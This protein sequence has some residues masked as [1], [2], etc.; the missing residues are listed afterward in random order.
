[1]PIEL[2]CPQCDTLLRVPDGSE[3]RAARCPSCQAMLRVPSPAQPGEN[4]AA[5]S[6]APAQQTPE[7]TSDWSADSS[8]ET[9][10]YVA[11]DR[12]AEEEDNP[13]AAPLAEPQA[14]ILGG[15]PF[16]LT[17]ARRL[18]VGDVFGAAQALYGRN[19]L[20]CFFGILVTTFLPWIPLAAYLLGAS[21]LWRQVYVPSLP[22]M[23]AMMIPLGVLACWLYAGM[24]RMT[25]RAGREGRTQFM[26]LFRTGKEFVSWLILAVMMIVLF[27]IGGTVIGGVL[28]GLVAAA[29]G[30]NNAGFILGMAIPFAIWLTVGPVFAVFFSQ[31][32][33]LIVDR[34][35]GAWSALGES[36]KL[37]AGYRWKLLLIFA[38]SIVGTFGASVVPFVSLILQPLW[39]GYVLL[40]WACTYL[41]LLGEPI[42]PRRF[43][44]TVLA[45]AP[46][47]PPAASAANFT[48][49]DASTSDKGTPDEAASDEAT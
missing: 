49:S 44:P 20:P 23:F 18:N 16:V 43:Q 25:L 42:D 34:K 40:L 12:S 30:M 41:S 9:F 15:S 11:V 27:A 24:M 46:P 36:V 35:A 33:W 37:T 29:P 14:A 1:M 21:A 47:P 5:S 3:G 31:S 26:E 19:F 38:I 4:A 28:A 22:V 2:R 39:Y 32:F 8:S 6:T 17:A 13:F 45:P 48:A 7:P 10:S